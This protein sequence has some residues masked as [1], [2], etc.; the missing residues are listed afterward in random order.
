MS[1]RVQLNLVLRHLNC[2][3]ARQAAATEEDWLERAF[4]DDG[5]LIDMRWT[6]TAVVSLQELLA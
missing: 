2:P 4:E 1:L 5:C 3:P 6:A